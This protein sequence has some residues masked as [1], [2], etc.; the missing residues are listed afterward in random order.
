M[1]KGIFFDAAGIL[2]RRA[3]PTVD[4]AMELLRNGGFSMDIPSEDQSQLL[5]YREQANLG[6]VNHEAFW[7]RFLIMHGVA[8][9]NLR[10]SFITRI[11]DYSDN[12]VPVPGA[13]EALQGLKQRNYLLGIVTDTMYPLEWKIR[14]LEKVGVAEFID[15]IACSTAIGVHKPDPGMYLNAIQQARL[16]PDESAF[17]GHLG[18]ELWGAH[19]AGMVTVAVNSNA[20][21]VADYYCKSILDLLS[22]P[23]FH[24]I[25]IQEIGGA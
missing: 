25:P 1:I 4:F 22:I 7:D 12:V 14:R 9:T 10:Q 6:R 24:A 17:V 19:N 16:A 13:R 8:D 21:A 11:I 23:I 3:T 5:A 20:D 18:I 15:V 2:Y